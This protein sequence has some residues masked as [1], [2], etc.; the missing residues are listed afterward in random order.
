[1]FYFT[2]AIIFVSK[3]VLVNNNKMFIIFI[4][5]YSRKY[6]NLFAK[7]STTSV[8]MILVSTPQ[9]LISLVK[10][11]YKIANQ[12]QGYK[13]I[14]NNSKTR[15]HFTHGLVFAHKYMNILHELQ[16]S[17]KLG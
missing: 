1:M 10:C 3:K 4:I 14:K 5:Y 13:N 8:L 9:I 17:F 12:E 6:I 15:L 16:D 2:K 11:R 7:N